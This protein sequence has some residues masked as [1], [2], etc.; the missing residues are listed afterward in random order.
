MNRTLIVIGLI[1][2]A[3]GLLWPWLSRLPLGQLP[4]DI[5]IRRE[6]ASFFF[7]ITTMILASLVL[8]GLLWLLNR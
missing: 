4:G 2:I 8:S 7:P 1:I 3:V 6:N 5:A